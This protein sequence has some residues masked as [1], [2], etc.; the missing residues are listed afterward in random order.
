MRS[1]LIGISGI[2]LAKRTTLSNWAIAVQARAQQSAPKGLGVLSQQAI[3]VKYALQR[4][5]YESQRNDLQQ[6]M[7]AET[8]RIQAKHAAERQT[9]VERQRRVQVKAQSDLAAIH[10]G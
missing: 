8:A 6:R 1:P 7:A 4:T 10:A 5:T 3:D 2:G 9:L